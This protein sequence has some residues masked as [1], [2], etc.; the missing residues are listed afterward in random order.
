M[1]EKFSAR[2][3]Q[4]LQNELRR[5]G[6]YLLPLR[7]FIGLGWLRASIEKIIEPEWHTGEA[8][9]AFFQEQLST[10]NIH[11]PFYQALVTDLFTPNAFLL[12]WIIIVGQLLAGLAIAA[13]VFTNLALLGGLFMNLNFIL[14][15]QV[16]PSAFYIVIQT[17]LFITNTGAVLGADS[18]ISRFVPS[19]FISAQPQFEYTSR[20]AKDRWYFLGLAII[21]WVISLMVIPFIRDYSPHSVDDPAM[22]MLILSALG[23]ISWFVMFIRSSKQAEAAVQPHQ[24]HS[25]KA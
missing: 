13:G 14:V 10:G 16:N 25:S 23:G 22:L 9:R 19:I 11:F 24:L 20:R 4:Y 3:W 6:A 1:K 21:S 5:E 7:F 2:A 12:S 15:G 17:A 8:L 18:L